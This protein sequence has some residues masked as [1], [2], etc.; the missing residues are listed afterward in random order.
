MTLS[1]GIDVGGTKIAGG[2]VDED[3][4][5]LEKLRV[6]SPATD[7]DA[8]EDAIAG[9]VRELASRH[10]VSAVGVGA[11]GYV[12]R[13]RAKVLIAPNLAWRDIDLKGELEEQIH[14]PVVVE[15]DANAAAW[16]EFRYGAGADVDDLLLV[17][18]GTGVGGGLVL[19]GQVHR[20]A[21]GVAA[22]IGH[23]RVV[24]DGLPCGCGRRGCFEQYAS[25]TALDRRARAA[26]ASGDAAAS[27]LLERAGG[28]AAAIDGPM[29]TEVA[30]SGDPFALAQLAELGRWLGAGIASLVAVLDPAVI[31][32]GGGVADAD[33]LLLDP[34]R[35]SFVEHLPGREHRP[36][37]EIRK[38]TLGNTA[39]LVG[40]ADLAR[41]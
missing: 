17:T 23:L 29:I 4:T 19:D 21:F 3:G 14:L 10:D 2:V 30:R 22:E 28:D 31:A 38:A 39:G 41:S 24:P 26:A 40:A 6:E 8:M 13:D 1:C 36:I 15:N 37:A 25:G 7:V 5:V 32:V 34:V 9:L 20:G 27:A 35:E 33:E 12:D 11:A 18:V 16:G